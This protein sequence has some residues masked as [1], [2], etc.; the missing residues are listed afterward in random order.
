MKR[1][2][3]L[4]VSLVWAMASSA[5]SP[6]P[7]DR[8]RGNSIEFFFYQN[9]T[10]ERQIRQ[11]F[12]QAMQRWN[13]GSLSMSMTG[14][15][16]NN[17]ACEARRSGVRIVNIADIVTSPPEKCG[18]FAPRDLATTFTIR[19]AQGEIVAADMFFK[20]SVPWA[21][22]D[23]PLRPQ[24]DFRRVAV[25]ELGH[26]AGLSLQS[27]DGKDRH[28]TD[29]SSIMY[30]V[31]SDVFMPSPQNLATLR[32]KYAQ[33]FPAPPPGDPSYRCSPEK[34]HYPVVE[35][36]SINA[37]TYMLE[38]C[39]DRDRF[40]TTYYFN[41]ARARRAKLSLAGTNGG[42]NVELSFGGQV[43]WRAADSGE[44]V[45]STE[46][47]FAAGRYTLTVSNGATSGPFSGA[48]EL[49]P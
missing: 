20:A 23:G 40:A 48:I 39:L 1:A 9:G 49:R 43:I 28:D 41:F 32:A 30:P 25:H 44:K 21:V 42:K 17:T 14:D 10:G 22:Y 34:P 35:L 46:G 6:Q 37:T 11:A 31:I 16:T 18:Q 27:F 13:V 33:A 36:G 2:I 47:E 8:W 7:I 19:T 29:P 24:M 15:A 45:K 5:Q 3:F 12:E 26:A 4:V 38:L